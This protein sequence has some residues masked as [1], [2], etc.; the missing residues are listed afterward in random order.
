L[1]PISKR[2]RAEM[3]K[4]QD[5]APY[6]GADCR[7]RKPIEAMM[8]KGIADSAASPCSSTTAGI[9]HVAPIDQF[10]VEKWNAIIR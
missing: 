1:P 4:Y 10:P 9:Q 7:A 3:Q 5:G 6:A 2:L 8:G